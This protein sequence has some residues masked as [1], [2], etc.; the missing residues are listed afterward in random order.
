[1]TRI[2]KKQMVL[3]WACSPKK[4]DEGGDKSSLTLVEN[5]FWKE[6]HSWVCFVLELA[7]NNG[8]DRCCTTYN[9]GKIAKK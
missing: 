1:M 9:H 6:Q 5:G 2:D 7:T 8:Y 4:D 3:G